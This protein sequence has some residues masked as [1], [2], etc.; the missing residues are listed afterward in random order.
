MFTVAVLGG[1]ALAAVIAG[2]TF[3]FTWP[4]VGVMSGLSGSQAA[5]T[6]ATTLVGAKLGLFDT[7]TIN[8]VLVVILA[9]LVVTPALVS[10]FGKRVSAVTD[11]VAALGKVVLVPVWGE[12]TRPA[13]ALAGRLAAE[14]RRDRARGQLRRQDVAA[15]RGGGAA[16]RSPSKAEEWLAKEGRES[17]TLF[18]VA[19]SVPEGLLETVI[20][21][22]ATLLVSEWR[23]SLR[24]AGGS[25][26]S[27]ALVA[28][29]G[30]GPDRA[31][32]RR[33]FRPAG[34]RR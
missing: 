28:L 6:L 16:R 34:A 2:R 24:N 27:E 26:A 25:E 3:Q 8:A 23:T 21:E 33:A 30:A 17:R 5:A 22:D 1:K 19:P 4:E 18:R 14:R 29:A 13:L 31:R 10:F 20:E 15:A 7:Q 12:S 32:R 9:S 11:E